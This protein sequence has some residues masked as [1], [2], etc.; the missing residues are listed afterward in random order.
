MQ[1]VTSQ[2]PMGPTFCANVRE[3]EDKATSISVLQLAS[4]LRAHDAILLHALWQSG[5]HSHM[6]L[7]TA[8]HLISCPTVL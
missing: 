1:N 8:C 6:L 4:S 2:Q 3:G 7:V 5:D